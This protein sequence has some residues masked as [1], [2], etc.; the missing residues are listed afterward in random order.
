MK[1]LQINTGNIKFTTVFEI[2]SLRVSEHFTAK[3]R[4]K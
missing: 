1:K 3:L 4:K 2:L